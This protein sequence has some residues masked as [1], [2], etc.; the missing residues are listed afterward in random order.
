MQFERIYDYS[1]APTIK[2]FNECSKFFRLLMGPFGSGKSSGCVAEIIDRGIQQQASPD[3][4]RRTKWAV[5]RNHYGQLT[6]T[7]MATFFYWLPPSYFGNFNKT[8]HHYIIDKIILDDGTKVEIEVLFRALDK[9]EHVANLLSMELT[10]AWFNEIREIPRIIV[11]AMEGRCVRYP[12]DVPITWTGIIADT[13]PP[14][15][16]SWIYTMFEETVPK[17]AKGEGLPDRYEIFKQPSGRSDNAENTKHLNGGRKYYTD[18]AIGKDP[19]FVKVYVDGEYGFVR[20]GKPVYQN[21]MDSI[22]CS[23]KPIN[24]IKGFPLIASYDFGM[25]P[26]CV[27]CQYLPMGKFNVIHEFYENNAGIR[28]FIR[29]VVQPFLSSRY[30][31]WEIVTTGDPAGMRRNDSDESSCYRELRSLGFPATPAYSNALLARVNAVDAFL[32]KMVEGK[33]AF[34]L[35]SACE[36]LRRGFIGEYK[37]QQFKGLH[38]RFSEIPLKNDFSHIH[39]ALQYACMLADKGIPG[40]RGSV[41]GSRYDPP[42]VKKRPGNPL[43][44]WT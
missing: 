13:N 2:R 34:Q 32:T 44:A 14:D 1:D 31:G 27:I 42:V 29:E 43:I 11:D 7:T 26:A 17:D 38:E 5:V 15:Q 23:E 4:I 21:Y 6:D 19:E 20:D 35:S 22:H 3:G 24:A 12:K 40:Y 10:G 28:S 18:L 41:A 37:L 33:P 39:D 8:E 9:P 36:L 25:T 30:R 16:Y